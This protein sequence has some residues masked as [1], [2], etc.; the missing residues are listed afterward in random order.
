MSS[1]R[2]TSQ[3]LGHRVLVIEDERQST[4]AI[5]ALLD[6][7][8]FRSVTV[9][10]TARSARARLDE[11]VPDLVLLDLRLP[12]GNGVDLIPVIRAK[13]P[14]TRILVLTVVTTTNCILS[15]LQAGADGYLYKDDLDIRLVHAMQDLLKGGAP[16]SSGAARVVLDHLQ[17]DAP[18]I[19]APRLTPKEKAV[20]ELLAIGHGYG[21]IA[22]DLGVE[23]NTIRT[24]I[25]S[26]YTKLG[27][28]NRAEAINVGWRLR[29]LREPDRDAAVAVGGR[30]DPGLCK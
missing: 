15:A 9:A 20:L 23:L 19:A 21:D 18:G 5:V 28:E 17:L 3:P 2:R 16:L 7:A 11:L 24:H 30:G 27:V 6:A 14:R 29:L 22:N 26:L 4:Q 10:D 1:P 12:D 8:G 25:R 13:A